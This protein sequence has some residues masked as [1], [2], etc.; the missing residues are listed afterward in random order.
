METGPG[1]RER[2]WV[3]STTPR[4]RMLADDRRELIV[5]AAAKVF[6]QRP[7]EEVSTTE[8]A[9]ACDISRG[10]MSH[11]FPSKR[12]LYLAVIRRLLDAPRLPMP[13]YREGDTVEDRIRHSVHGWLDLV[14]RSKQTWLTTVG[15]LGDSRDEEIQGLLEDNVERTADQICEIAGLTDVCD[16]PEV[17][18]ALRGYS[19]FAMTVTRR[20][21]QDGPVSRE[22]VETLLVDSLIDLVRRTIPALLDGDR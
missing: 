18:L 17:R 9:R 16:H 10:L 4:V 12:D 6:S 13:A 14:L 22:Q 21:L 7:Y 2:M 20:W 19:A 11:Y 8:L 15:F 3:M 5:K 1:P